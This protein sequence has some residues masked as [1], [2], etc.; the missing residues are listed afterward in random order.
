L[1]MRSPAPSS[2]SS[3]RAKVVL[4]APSSPRR[5]TTPPRRSAGAS[6]CASMIVAASPGRSILVAETVS[7]IYT[8]I[9]KR[10]QIRKQVGRQR[11]AF[12]RA[13]RQFPGASMDADADAGRVPGRQTLRQQA[14][15]YTGQR[16]AG[17]AA[18]EPRA[19][20]GTH[21]G[22]ALRG[23]DQGARALQHRHRVVPPRDRVC[24]GEAVILDLAGAAI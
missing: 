19:A 3:A 13:R 11:A 14:R 7:A 18:G 2:R 9:Y 6:R 5:Y 12:A 4:P 15:D 23:G 16:V 17:A 1:L 22:A 8:A 10:A 21:R 20:P 24:R